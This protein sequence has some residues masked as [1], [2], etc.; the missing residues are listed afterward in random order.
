MVKF[1]KILILFIM[2]IFIFIPKSLGDDNKLLEK[3]NNS[4]AYREENARDEIIDDF[5]KGEIT[6]EDVKTL[7]KEVLRTFLMK[8]QVNEDEVLTDKDKETLSTIYENLESN[9]NSDRIKTDIEKNKETLEN[10]VIVRPS[11]TVEDNAENND[12]LDEAIGIITKDGHENATKYINATENAESDA[13]SEVIDATISKTTWSAIQEKGKEKEYL[14]FLEDVSENTKLGEYGS[15]KE[16]ELLQARMATI[17]DSELTDAQKRQVNRIYE[18]LDA[19]TKELD[20][21]Y[22][23]VELQKYI[24]K[25]PN[26]GDIT[27][28]SG[29]SIDN[30]MTD[31]EEFLNSAKEDI[32]NQENLQSFSN[33]LYNILLTIAVAVAV[34]VGGI[35]G[36]KLMT[37]S[38][39]DKAEVKQFLLPY[40]IG[41][42]VVFGGFGIWKL[43]VTILQTI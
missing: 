29:E 42:I 41:C 27:G 37:S 38:A 34:I 15:K 28:S 17:A 32:V 23:E 12:S 35:I 19:R 7:D 33:M 21:N 3:L 8:I 31:G 40:V 1:L 22:K 13:L 4:Q 39:E 25:N 5:Q 11:S 43:A 26:V 2:L 18:N 36:L 16:L 24:F 14:N 6:A 20:I 10:S 30:V 9:K